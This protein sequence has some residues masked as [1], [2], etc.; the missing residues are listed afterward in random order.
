MWNMLSTFVVSQVVAPSRDVCYGEAQ[1]GSRSVLSQMIFKK[2][3][4]IRSQIGS[5]PPLCS[6]TT[7]HKFRYQQVDVISVYLHQETQHKERKKNRR[8]ETAEAATEWPRRITTAILQGQQQQAQ[9]LSDCSIL[10]LF[11][12]RRNFHFCF[13]VN[14][15]TLVFVKD[16]CHRVV[17]QLV[18]VIR[19][20]MS[21]S[22]FLSSPLAVC[23]RNSGQLQSDGSHAQMRSTGSRRSV[24]FRSSFF[25]VQQSSKRRPRR[26][27]VR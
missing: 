27:D 18:V 22:L 4:S 17:D 23:C 6:V 13:S 15:I 11:S 3:R 5:P 14:R 1:C 20:K 8:R 24:A 21:I 16:L 19:N 12:V 9:Q 7:N 10:Q 25:F 26:E 2:S